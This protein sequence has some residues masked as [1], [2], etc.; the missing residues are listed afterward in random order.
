MRSQRP[1]T[2]QP[3]ICPFTP[4]P[5]APHTSP[6]SVMTQRRGIQNESN[7][8]SYEFLQTPS[9]PIRVPISKG[10][11]SQKKGGDCLSFFAFP[12]C[13]MRRATTKMLLLQRHFSVEQS[14]HA[15]RAVVCCL[16]KSRPETRLFFVLLFWACYSCWLTL[17]CAF[18]LSHSFGNTSLALD[19]SVKKHYPD[20]WV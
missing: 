15:S 16:C 1:P 3:S 8:S 7:K 2:H 17:Y 11:L 5:A 12:T 14:T 4:H 9:H 18:T 6:S 19:P 10:G 13:D 20:K